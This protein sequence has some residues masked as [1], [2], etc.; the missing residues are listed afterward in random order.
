MRPIIEVSIRKSHSEPPQDL[1]ETYR[2]LLHDIDKD[3][4]RK[5]TTSA[6]WTVLELRP[7]FIEELVEACAF[8]AGRRPELESESSRLQGYHFF[9]LLQDLMIVETPLPIGS[10][11]ESVRE[12]THIITLARVSL[13]EYLTL[14]NRD[15]TANH[16]FRFRA[17]YEHCDI[18]RS[19]IS[20]IFHFDKPNATVANYPLLRYAWLHCE[21]RVNGTTIE[22]R[23]A[24]AFELPR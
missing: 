11:S 21:K 7:L 18:A 12:R 4:F 6:E 10:L 9:K 19:C 17:M 22:F 8:K 16:P 3:F 14:E 20:F 15:T 2:R 24:I 23:P 5:S 13:V 1:N